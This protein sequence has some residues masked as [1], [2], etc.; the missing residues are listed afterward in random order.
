MASIKNSRKETENSFS[1][2]ELKGKKVKTFLPTRNNREVV[3]ALKDID[4]TTT[5]DQLIPH[6]RSKLK[7]FQSLQRY[8]DKH[9]KEGLYLLQFR[10]C[11]DKN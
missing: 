11:N 1:R 4:P 5:A 9:L 3:D 10:K 6:S 2:L 7:K 8:F